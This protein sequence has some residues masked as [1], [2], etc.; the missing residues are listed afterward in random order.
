[1]TDTKEPIA[2]SNEPIKIQDATLSRLL[3][4]GFQLPHDEKRGLIVLLRGQAGTGKSTLALQLLDQFQTAAKKFYCTLEQSAQD[5]SHKLHAMRTTRALDA[6]QAPDFENKRFGYNFGAAQ[7]KWADFN[8]D[9]GIGGEIAEVWAETSKTKQWLP[10]FEEP[11]DE[12][13]NVDAEFRKEAIKRVSTAG[14]KEPHQ[15][16]ICDGEEAGRT[17]GHEG[18]FDGR[19]ARAIHASRLLQTPEEE[20]KMSQPQRVNWPIVVLDGLSLLSTSERTTLEL[21]TIIDRMRRKFQLSILVFEPNDDTMCYLD[22]HSDMV[23]EL[24]S[25]RI[26]KPLAYLIHEMCISKARYQDCALGHHQF[27]I[28]KSG[29]VFFPSLHFQVHHYN[30]MELELKRS[31]G[32]GTAN[33]SADVAEKKQSDPATTPGTTQNTTAS[34]ANGGQ[35]KSRSQVTDGSLID[36]IFSPAKG[37][38]IVLLGPRNSFKT[39]LCLDFLAR[40]C[41]GG[42]NDGKEEGLLISLIDNAPNI[43]AGLKCPW[44]DGACGNEICKTGCSNCSG[45]FIK[46]AHAFCQRPGCITPAEF[47]YYVRQRLEKL[48]TESRVVFWDLTQMDYRFP[49][50]KEDKMLLPALMD[51]FKSRPMK[52][53]FMGAGNAE[54]TSSASAMADH[55]LFCWRS[56][57]RWTNAPLGGNSTP[58]S[59]LMLYVDR[60]SVLAKK[61]G[62]VLYAVPVD[63][64]GKLIWPKTQNE[65]EKLKVRMTEDP[66]PPTLPGAEKVNEPVFNLHRNDRREIERIT[67]MQ[68]V[69]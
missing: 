27:K 1:M 20:R 19:H 45:G 47:F 59:S 62:K 42:T 69:Q 37:E 22:H 63:E 8:I 66:E 2:S 18:P 33:P 64:N 5:L 44:A 58:H 10:L 23:I 12:Q 39:Q 65:L 57:A 13:K 9:E 67:R 30:Y 48:Q 11:N 35:S 4:G 26:E 31:M 53:L 68:G 16:Q 55:V 15:I 49:L 41:W 7:A 17:T 56:A 25:T 38:S 52:S 21:E 34:P 3:R 51:H 14:Q 46:H 50:F 54:N 24:A 6:F 60:T 40:G 32:A 36:L 61:S 43:E 28:R 29:L